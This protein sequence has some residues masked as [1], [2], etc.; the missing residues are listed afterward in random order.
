[1]LE[2]VLSISYTYYPSTNLNR[3]KDFHYPPFTV[4]GTKAQ[5]LGTLLKVRQYYCKRQA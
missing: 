2:T 3:H 1:M 5:R 4:K